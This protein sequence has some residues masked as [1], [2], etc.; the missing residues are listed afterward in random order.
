MSFFYIITH[1]EHTVNFK[2]EKI[3]FG[4]FYRPF[5][6]SEVLCYS[7]PMK[8]TK[9]PIRDICFTGL[10]AALISVSAL[11]IP[12]PGGIPFTLQTFMIMLAGIILGP[13]KGVL[14][15]LVYIILGTVGLPVFSGFRGGFGVISG[16]T[17]GF[18]ISFAVIAFLAGIGAQGN[19]IIK[20]MIFI[21]AGVLLNYL[22]G[23]LWYDFVTG[24]GFAAAFTVCVLPFI[25]GDAVKVVLAVFAGRQIKA[26]LSK[27]KIWFS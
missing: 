15:V 16:P 26:A 10:F 22:C 23:M 5:D 4:R 27:G 25:P 18:I 20:P 12:A 6:F 24:N 2:R 13:K 21:T 9:F 3:K 17:G 7:F 1:Y 8:N 11:S 19:K 14:A